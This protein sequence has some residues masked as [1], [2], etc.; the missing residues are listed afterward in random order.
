[1]DAVL[2]LTGGFPPFCAAMPVANN[3][4]LL[5]PPL[6]QG[7]N[8]QYGR[9]CPLSP[10]CFPL[11]LTAFLQFWLHF[12]LGDFFPL[13]YNPSTFKVFSLHLLFFFYLLKGFAFSLV[14]IS[15]AFLFR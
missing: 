11:F 3:S 10:L 12:R 1:M 2:V 6:F 15:F 4:K 9:N 14:L 7:P 8:H 13:F 5:L